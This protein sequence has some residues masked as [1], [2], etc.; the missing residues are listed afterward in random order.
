MSIICKIRLD[1]LEML[2]TD[3]IALATGLTI[4]SIVSVSASAFVTIAYG[5]KSTGSATDST[6]ETSGGDICLE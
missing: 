5:G 6:T 3:S 2:T 4:E 1:K